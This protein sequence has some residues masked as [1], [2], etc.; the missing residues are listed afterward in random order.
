VANSL[1]TRLTYQV[2]SFCLTEPNAGSDAFALQTT[3][4]LDKSGDF[5]VLN[6]SKWC[7]N[8]PLTIANVQLDLQLGRS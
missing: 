2:G 8:A 7:V 6:G 4:K 3:A 5:Y 1:S